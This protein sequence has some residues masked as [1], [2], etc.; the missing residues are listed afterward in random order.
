MGYLAR[1]E[2]T[3]LR[4]EDGI[5]K[6]NGAGSGLAPSRRGYLDEVI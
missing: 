4:V 1:A 3:N 2:P 6:P 5:I